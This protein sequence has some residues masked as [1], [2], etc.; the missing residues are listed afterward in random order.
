MSIGLLLLYVFSHVLS[1]KT[2]LDSNIGYSTDD[3][4]ID[5]IDCLGFT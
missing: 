3:Q 4:S 2:L 1:N 5:V